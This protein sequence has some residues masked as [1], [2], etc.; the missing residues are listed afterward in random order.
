M[1]AGLTESK[2]V[3]RELFG[4]LSLCWHSQPRK[5]VYNLERTSITRKL[6]NSVNKN[7]PDHRPP[8]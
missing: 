2:V 6:D 1:F 3:K 7:E 4:G 8:W 5:P